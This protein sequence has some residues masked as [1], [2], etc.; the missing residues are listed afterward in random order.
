MWFQA[1][2]IELALLGGVGQANREAW[3]TEART[4]PLERV[5][6]PAQGVRIAKTSPVR[7]GPP[8]SS[9]EGAEGRAAKVQ[10]PS[11]GERSETDLM[12]EAL[13]RADGESPNA[14]RIDRA[15]AQAKADARR[16]QIAPATVWKDPFADDPTRPIPVPARLRSSETKAR[17][18]SVVRRELARARAETAVAQADAARAKADAAKAEASA[19]LAQAVAARHEAVA[20][21]AACV[22][23]GPGG[24]KRV[25]AYVRPEPRAHP[26]GASGGNG[27][28]AASLPRAARKSLPR[29]ADPGTAPAAA[30]PMSPAPAADPL[31]VPLADDALVSSHPGGGILVVPITR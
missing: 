13:V 12:L 23:P 10:A 8:T 9:G 16:D 3:G 18:L 22:D 19:A 28:V 1:I 24:G 15:V 26:R 17:E 20:A 31:T 29:T 11:K 14:K 21:R 7:G 25:S 5:S 4:R 30:A 2:V 6:Q 27:L